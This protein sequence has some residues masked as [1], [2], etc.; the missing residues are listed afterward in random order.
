MANPVQQFEI[1][2]L[3]PL[4]IGGVDVSFTNSSLWMIIGVVVATLGLSIVSRKRAMVPGRGQ[5][6]AESLYEFIASMIRDNIGSE[7]RRYFPLVFTLFANS[8]C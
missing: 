4:H 7:G 8:P 6:F 5:M 2:P 1:T 3:L